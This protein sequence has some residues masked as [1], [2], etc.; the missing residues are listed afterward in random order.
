MQFD[1]AKNRFLAAGDDF[2]IKIWDMDNTQLLTCIDTDGGLPVSFNDYFIDIYHT[3]NTVHWA[4][5]LLVQKCQAS[6]RI[7]F[8]K[9]GTLLAVSANENGI[10]ILANADGFRVLRAF[11]N[12]AFDASRSSEGAKV[13]FYR[14][15]YYVLLIL[16]TPILWKN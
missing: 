9:N 14:L 3:E 4:A 5:I 6:P 8:N 13:F 10:K 7:R 15:E 2:S 16:L 1:T 12:L 11:E